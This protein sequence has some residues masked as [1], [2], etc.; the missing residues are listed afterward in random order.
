MELSQ[1]LKPWGA[2][3]G[4]ALAACT[5]PAFHAGPTHPDVR[6]LDRAFR[7]T[8]TVRLSDFGS[9]GRGGPLAAIG[10]PLW[11]VGA[12]SGESDSIFGE[13]TAAA[14]DRR[15]A[16]LVLDGKLS[17]VK[18]YSPD[19]SLLQRVGRPGSGPGE[20]RW[21]VDLA[22]D[23]HGHLYV[24]DLRHL[25]RFVLEDE[26]YRFDRSVPTVQT[27]PRSI[28][29]LGEVVYVHGDDADA[30]QVATA[31]A[32]S[33]QMHRR[34][35]GG[36]S[37]PNPIVNLM[38]NQGRIACDR[39]HGQVVFA[40]ATLGE[41]RAVDTSGAT[42]WLAVIEDFRPVQL[43]EVPD[44]VEY[45]KVQRPFDRV[46]ALVLTDSLVLLQVS[47]YE[48]RGAPATP[49]SQV[50][51]LVLALADGSVKGGGP[52]A[53]DAFLA[54]EQGIA[55]SA[56]HDPFPRLRVWDLGRRPPAPDFSSP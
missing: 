36:Y 51:S 20:F 28:C 5:R 8:T 1:F 6:Y 49:P 3:L 48:R 50:Y 9:G 38:L 17:E 46:Q 33:G 35:P 22:T 13:I 26:G 15:R 7:P 4:C 12:P 45:S 21:P 16:I 32:V 24:A 47:R 40:S 53:H 54:F 41:I 23:G 44:G 19:G 25:H 10:D 42:K 31:Y 14:I 11:S 18:V 30:P 43:V 37:S 55:V 29:V 52:V 2:L 39:R 34:L 27:G 56:S